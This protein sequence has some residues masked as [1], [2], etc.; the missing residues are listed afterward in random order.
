M[1]ECADLRPTYIEFGNHTYDKRIEYIEQASDNGT[2]R[3]MLRRTLNSSTDE[4]TL[5][6]VRSGEVVW[7]GTVFY[8]YPAPF[9]IQENPGSWRPL[10]PEAFRVGLDIAFRGADYWTDLTHIYVPEVNEGQV[11]ELKRYQLIRHGKTPLPEITTKK[12]TEDVQSQMS[13]QKLNSWLFPLGSPDHTGRIVDRS[14]KPVPVASDRLA[15]LREWLRQQNLDIPIVMLSRA[16][17]LE[18]ARQKAVRD[19][20]IP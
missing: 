12:T 20:Q 5:F 2:A 8:E 4:V 11:R 7:T 17:E 10:T 16:A 6:S 1:V 19:L 13:A 9:L 3:L 18:P 14:G 15:E